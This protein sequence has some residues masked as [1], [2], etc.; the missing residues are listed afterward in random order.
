MSSNS[1]GPKGS[2]SLLDFLNLKARS[3]DSSLRR[4]RINCPGLP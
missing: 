4:M 3:N 2:H 1:Y